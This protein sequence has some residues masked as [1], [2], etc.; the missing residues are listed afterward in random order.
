M[1]QTDDYA[2]NILGIFNN[3]IKTVTM[4]RNK[5]KTRS[6]V[7]PSWSDEVKPFRDDAVPGTLYG[8]AQGNHSTTL[9]TTL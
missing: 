8:N 3:S 7:V 1:L 2:T 5:T 9:Y 6:K 4:R